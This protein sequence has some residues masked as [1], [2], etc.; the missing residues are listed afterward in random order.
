[1]AK[2]PAIAAIAIEEEACAVLR[3]NQIFANEINGLFVSGSA[4]P[5][6]EEN[7][8]SAHVAPAWTPR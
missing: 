5:I 8:F 4:A 6:V 1:M 2:P 3:R 7:E